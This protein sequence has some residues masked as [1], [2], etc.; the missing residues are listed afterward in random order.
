MLVH[1]SAGIGRTGTFIVIDHVIAALKKSTP[2]QVDI[3]EI[4]YV[5]KTHTLGHRFIE[6]WCWHDRA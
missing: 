2:D 6:G 1:C 5:K 3:N 4:V